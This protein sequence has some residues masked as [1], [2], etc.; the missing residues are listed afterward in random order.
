MGTPI[1]EPTNAPSHNQNLTPFERARAVQP[2]H[3]IAWLTVPRDISETGLLEP[4][5][6]AL[7]IAFIDRLARRFG[8]S[9]PNHNTQMEKRTHG[10][11]AIE[12]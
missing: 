1:T 7:L 9:I 4:A 10:E 12:S 2:G 5:I 8:L 11:I 6:T 3:Q